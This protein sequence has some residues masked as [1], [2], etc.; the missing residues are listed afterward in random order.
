MIT[1]FLIMLKFLIFNKIFTIGQ[2]MQ[3]YTIS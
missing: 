3:K 1:K 2:D